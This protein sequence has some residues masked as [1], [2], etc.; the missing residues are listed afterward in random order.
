MKPHRMDKVVD[1]VRDRLEKITVRHKLSINVPEDLP[2]VLIDEGRIGEV[3][4]NLVE[5]AA[6][7]SDHNTEIRI[8][9]AGNGNK[10]TVSVAD[11]G[12]GIA[13]ELHR[14]IFDRFFQGNGH[15]N[16]RRRGTGLGLAICR[17][18]IEAHGGHIRVESEEGK[19]ARFSFNLPT[20]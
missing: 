8:E 7:Y 6:K 3:L 19:G 11:E 10:V 17:G 14:K 1:F 15:K 16:G 13:P 2:P 18:I 12:I 20:A 9:T 4:T 5:N